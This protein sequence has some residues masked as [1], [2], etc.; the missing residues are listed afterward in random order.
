MLKVSM[1]SMGDSTSLGGQLGAGGV[2]RENITYACLVLSLSK[3]F[4]RD[5]HW[6][7]DTD[8][9]RHLV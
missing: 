8:L 6:Q 2:L 4:A 5:H 9:D 1:A 3:K 7:Q